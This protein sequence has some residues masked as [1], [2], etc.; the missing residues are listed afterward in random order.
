MIA[1]EHHGAPPREAYPETKVTQDRR[2]GRQRFPESGFS[3]SRPKPSHSRARGSIVRHADCDRYGRRF[4]GAGSW[5]RGLSYR[6]RYGGRVSRDPGARSLS[7][8]ARLG[9]ERVVGGGGRDRSVRRAETAAWRTSERAPDVGDVPDAIPG[10]RHDPGGGRC[11]PGAPAAEVARRMSPRQG[12]GRP[13]FDFAHLR[14]VHFARFYLLEETADLDGKPIPASLVFMSEVDAPLRRHPAELADVAGD[15]IDQ[16][17]GHCAW[18]PGARC[19]PPGLDR[20]AALK[21]SCPPAPS[22]STR[23][24][25]G[26]TRY[27]RRRG[28]GRRWRTIST[29]ATGPSCSA[30][31]VRRD[32]QAYVAGRAD[33][34]W[35][36]KPPAPPPLPFRIREAIRQ[37]RRAVSPPAAAA[38]LLARPPVLDPWR[39]G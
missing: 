10:R 5:V 8:R 39:S 22:T 2:R 15:G 37:G 19:P 30:A 12:P 6:A 1:A 34:S 33:L 28:C 14:G 29:S 13:P 7:G 36:G 21:I 35:A 32:L 3:R 26:W 24:G 9:A 23:S 38:V 4:R 18:L 27:A 31:E 20:L 16:A 17:F 25:A 11:R